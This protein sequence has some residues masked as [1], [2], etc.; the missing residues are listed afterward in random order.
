VRSLNYQSS[1]DVESPDAVVSSKHENSLF[2]FV[3]LEVTVAYRNKRRRKRGNHSSPWNI[4]G[5]G[6]MGCKR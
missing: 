1:I 3:C 4:Q 5:C 6:N 2:L